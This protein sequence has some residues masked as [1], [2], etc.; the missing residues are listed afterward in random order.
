MKC[1]TGFGK[2]QNDRINNTLRPIS[3]R[4]LD[5]LKFLRSRFW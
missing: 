4:E 3:R 1:F 5:R 2:T